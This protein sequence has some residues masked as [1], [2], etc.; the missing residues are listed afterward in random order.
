MPRCLTVT[1]HLPV[2]ELE[3]RDP[4]ARD[5]AARITGPSSG[6]SPRAST[7]PVSPRSS[8]TPSTGS[9]P[10]STAT[11]P[12]VRPG[13]ATAATAIPAAGTGRC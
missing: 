13:W 3:T 6:S 9:G 2:V 5:P 4:V 10:W 1:P 11:T 7:A 8:A 12:R